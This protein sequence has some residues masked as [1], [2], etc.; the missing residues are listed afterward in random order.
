MM[1]KINKRLAG[2]IIALIGINQGLVG[3][4]AKPN[5]SSALLGVAL[6]LIGYVFIQ[7]KPEKKNE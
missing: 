4:I 2:V 3:L 1:K 5:L 6:F 7:E